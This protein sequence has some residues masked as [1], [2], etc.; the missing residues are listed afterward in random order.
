MDENCQNTGIPNLFHFVKRFTERKKIRYFCTN[1]RL[2][3]WVGTIGSGFVCNLMTVGFW[4][5]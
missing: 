4:C 1:M 2:R 3:A 5:W